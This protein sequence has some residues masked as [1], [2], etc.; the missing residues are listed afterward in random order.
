MTYSM[1]WAEMMIW[2]HDTFHVFIY[3]SIYDFL[4]MLFHHVFKQT[5]WEN[6]YHLLCAFS[7]Y[8]STNALGKPLSFTMCFLILFLDFLWKHA[9]TQLALAGETS[10]IYYVLPHWIGL[11]GKPLS[12]TMCFLIGSGFP[13][14]ALPL[15]K[16]LLFTMCFPILFPGGRTGE[17][18]IIYYV[19][20]HSISRFSLKTRMGSTRSYWGN[21]YHL[22]CA[23]PSYSSIFFENTHGPNPLLLEKPLSFTMCFPIG[24]GYWGNPYHLLCASPSYFSI[25]FENTHGP[26][27]LL[28]GK[29]ISFT[30][31]FPIGFILFPGGRIV[32]GETPIIYYVLLHPIL[33]RARFSLKTCMGPTRSYWGN[34]Y[35][36]LCASPSC[37]PTGAL[38]LGKPLLFN[39]C[40]PIGSGHW[41]NLYYL[42]CA[43]PLDRVIGETSIIY[44]VL[45]HPIL[46]RAPWGHPYYLLCASPSNRVSR[47]A[48]CHWGTL[49]YFVCAS[50]SWSSASAL[51]L[52]KPLLFSGCFPSYRC[53][54][55]GTDPDRGRCQAIPRDIGETSII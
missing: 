20:P 45:P 11:L 49:Y 26:N 23:S 34:P 29:P 40:F 31:C 46:R 44:Y 13:T 41:G 38:P 12:F 16:P 42:L 28:L 24:S 30:M 54:R 2:H 53:S 27:P 19:L 50:P 6:F 15:G 25:F 33:R 18:P 39:G 36:L 3:V 55:L 7:L 32:I 47:S 4:S 14:G 37:S 48:H 43:S 17:T 51:P 8:F 9:W 1:L 22:L 10:I 52:G 21:P 5:H 35:H